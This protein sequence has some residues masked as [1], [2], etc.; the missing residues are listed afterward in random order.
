[1]NPLF[2]EAAAAAV[3]W[4]L[5][6][7]AGYLVK[8]GIWAEADAAGYVAAAALAL[9][10]LAWSWW[11]KSTMRTKLVTAAAMGPTTEAAVEKQIALGKAAP[12]NTPKN[13]QPKQN[14]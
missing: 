11:Q 7:V 1:M 2:L 8:A 10:A 4:V 13:E 6:V 9:V 14:L 3:R 12:T 5:A